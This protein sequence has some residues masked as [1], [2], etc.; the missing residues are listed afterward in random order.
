M[1][2]EYPRPN[3]HIP[4]AHTI[5]EMKQTIIMIYFIKEKTPLQE[6]LEGY[7][8]QERKNYPELDQYIENKEWDNQQYDP[9]STTNIY[10]YTSTEMDGLPKQF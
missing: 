6:R 8:E 3:D 1:K 5:N 10:K 9:S 2:N 4:G 7:L